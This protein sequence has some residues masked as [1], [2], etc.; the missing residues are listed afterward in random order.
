MYIS[1]LYIKFLPCIDSSYLYCFSL[2]LYNEHASI[3][4][5]TQGLRTN[6]GAQDEYKLRKSSKYVKRGAANEQ[7]VSS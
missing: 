3:E 2:I 1:N 7:I 4:G 6:H 5:D